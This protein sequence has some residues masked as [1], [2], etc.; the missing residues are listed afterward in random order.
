MRYCV[1]RQDI[2]VVQTFDPNHDHMTPIVDSHV[3]IWSEDRERYPRSETPYPA[4]PELL[5]AEMAAAGVQHAVIVLPMYYAFDNHVLA[6]T[7]KQYAPTF[8]GVGVIDPRGMAA[9]GRLT[10]LFERDGIRGV[11]LRA[12]LEEQWFATAETIP[13][14]RRAGELGVP[15]CVLGLPHH[16]PALQAMVEKSPETRVVIDH[17]LHI[18]AAEG[19]E[20]TAFKALL[21]LAKSPN[22]YLKLSNVR[23]WAAGP[24]PNASAQ[25]LVR[26]MVASFGAGRIMWGSDWPHVRV[27][28]GYA[29]CLDFV[30]LHLPWLSDVERSQILGGTASRLWGFGSSSVH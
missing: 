18:P 29:R 22:V 6:D 16:L 23:R 2:L 12:N 9:A 15:L 10:Q 7:L 30:R 8:A 21:G 5:L 19:V 20:G 26:S 24:Y 11:R 4:A 17:L 25:P 27:G 1:T 3:H 13:L 28:D 14:W